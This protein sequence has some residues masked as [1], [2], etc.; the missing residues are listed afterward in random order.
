MA[1]EKDNGGQADIGRK[2]AAGLDR[3][4]KWS[5]VAALAQVAIVVVGV[6]ITILVYYCARQADDD[7]RR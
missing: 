6:V 5:D 4:M 7:I 2:S 1:G 3:T